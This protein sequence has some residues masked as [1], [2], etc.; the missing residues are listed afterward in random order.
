[1]VQTL[2]IVVRK[3]M[4]LQDYITLGHIEAMNKVIVLTGSI[5]GC[6]YSQNCSLH[7]MVRTHTNG[8]HSAKQGES[9]EPLWM[10]LL[11]D[12]VL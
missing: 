1:M 8:M 10:E 3:V 4:N 2:L 11:A 7:G 6:A 9:L 12:D 5:V